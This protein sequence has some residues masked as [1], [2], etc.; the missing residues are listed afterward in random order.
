MRTFAT[1][2]TT[3]AMRRLLIV[4]AIFAVI[5]AL[6]LARVWT[7]RAPARTI[8]VTLIV[9]SGASLPAAAQQLH[10]AHLVSSP[11]LFALVA[12]AFGASRPI[13]A[14]EY[15]IPLGAGWAEILGLLQ[16]GHTV[17]HRITIPEGLPAVLVVERL[18]AEPLLIGPT[19]TPLEG[20]VL[21]DTYGFQRGEPRARVLAWMQT[22]MARQLRQLWN[23]RAPAAA[24]R[25]PAEAI[26]LASIVEK[27]TALPAERRLVAGVYSNRLRLGM[28][29]DA[30][31]TL[32]YPV[33]QGRP[34]GR[35]ILRS[36]IVADTGYNTY[37]KPGLP[38]GPIANPGR[39]SIAAV[40]DP[41]PTDALYFVA[42]GHG[43]HIFARTLAE[44]NANVAR[45]RALKA[46]SAS[47][48]ATGVGAKP[49]A[50]FSAAS[51][52]D[53]RAKS[54]IFRPSSPVK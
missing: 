20:T 30:D 41:A 28:K 51:I 4:L 19:P 38:R 32:I 40:L 21:P 39:A 50:V 36:E 6:L 26:T 9:P 31:P 49:A 14:G 47:R 23:A 24:V 15:A 5:A 13:R 29:L 7:H 11:H 53:S 12:R 43:G 8:T 45:Y 25:T 1:G 37:L 35:R 22:A 17:Q 27:E 48:A 54:S 34:L 52:A 33:T 18:A 44:Q 3:V 2:A 16:S 10:A 46:T 42:N